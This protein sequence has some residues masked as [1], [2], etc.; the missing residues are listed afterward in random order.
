MILPSIA[1]LLILTSAWA[2]TFAANTQSDSWSNQ[3]HMRIW[4]W[5][6][7]M[8]FWMRWWAE[9]MQNLSETDRQAL[10]TATEKAISNK[11]YDA[12]KETHT[13]YGITLNMTEEQFNTMLT[14]KTEMDSERTERDALRTKI[15]E[16]IKN[17]NFSTRKTLN[18]N[19]PILDKIDTQ[20]KFEKLQEIE[21][22][23][24]KIDTLSTE[25]WMNKWGWFWLWFW[26]NAR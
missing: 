8:W 7:W 17:W 19:N 20:E 2:L 15:E 16:A 21:S 18:K 6:K 1:G 22:Y 24:S 14:K 25:L 9:W 23:K 3:G 10:L 5:V 11:D 12:F 26:R 4:W 13:K